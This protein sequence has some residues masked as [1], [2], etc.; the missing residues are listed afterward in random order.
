MSLDVSVVI[1]FL[2]EAESLTELSSLLK[3][4]L[5]ENNFSYELIFVDD[6]SSDNSIPI[7]L[8]AKKSD[9]NI[10]IIK[11]R[12]N[13]GKSAAL[14]A[15]FQKAIGKYLITMDAD[16]QDNPNEIP[17]LIAKL[18]EG[19]D[20]VSGWK[21]ERHDPIS[22]TI[23]SKFFNYITRKITGI[24]LHD[25]NCGLKGY[26]LE[27]AK[28]VKVYGELHRF[29]PVLAKEKGFRISEI[30]VKHQARKH[31]VSKF[32]FSRFMNG[33]FDL[34]T[35]VFITSYTQ[36][37]LHLFG[38]LGTICLF[39]GGAIELYLAIG[40][41]FG[42]WIGNRPIFFVGIL[43]LISGLQLFSIGLVSEMI[44]SKSNTESRFSVEEEL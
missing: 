17:S 36:R 19:Y 32:G 13:H 16:L 21:K 31:G 44:T 15:G 29:I 8:E 28:E 12:R 4:V 23:P 3:S 33:F 42:Q 5:E 10:K 27:V 22:K 2:N 20:L 41:V 9:P 30:A 40:W 34:L 26:R 25:F 38:I 6:G 7:L 1:P 35:V 39:L 14:S 37:P 43:L 24:E 18:E 11:F